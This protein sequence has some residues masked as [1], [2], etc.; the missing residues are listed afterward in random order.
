MAFDN[1]YLNRK[2]RRQPYRG[3]K[4]MDASCRNHGSCPYCENN[5]KH[6]DERREL[7]AREQIEGTG[8]TE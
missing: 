7:E 3:S 6:A 1:E 5:R 2:D 4:A 8:E